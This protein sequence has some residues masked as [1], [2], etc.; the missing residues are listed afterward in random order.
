MTGKH[1]GWTLIIAAAALEYS[2]M[3][4]TSGTVG[5]GTL[6]QVEGALANFDELT[7]PSFRV[8]FI[9]GAVGIYLLV[10]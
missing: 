10:K 9:L 4:I 5:T 2:H 8:A 3:Q 6:A 1:L 7:G